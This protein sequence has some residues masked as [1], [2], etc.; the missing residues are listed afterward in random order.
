MIFLHPAVFHVFRVQVFPGPG[1]SSSRFF[2]VQVFQVPGFSGSRFFRVQVFQSPGFSESRFFR[3]RVQCPDP[4]FRN[5]PLLHGCSPVNLLHIFR[6][7]FYKNTSA[8]LLLSLFVISIIRR[9]FSVQLCE[10]CKFSS[11]RH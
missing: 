9:S 5:S 1:F 11:L 3:V 10:I 7:P 4:G 2:R 8:G 6:T